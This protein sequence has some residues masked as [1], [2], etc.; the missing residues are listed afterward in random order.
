[1]VVKPKF[2]EVGIGSVRIDAVVSAVRSRPNDTPYYGPLC[3][4][5]TSSTKTGSVLHIVTHLR[6]DRVM[7]TDY[8]WR[9]FDEDRLRGSGDVRADR[10]TDR[11]TGRQAE[12]YA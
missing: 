5:M 4:S 6:Q 3:K 7:I 10:H 1:M 2:S 8:M 11:Q 12:R 9:K